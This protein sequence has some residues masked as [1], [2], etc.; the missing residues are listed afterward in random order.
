MRRL[1]GAGNGIRMGCMQ[2][3]ACCAQA[4]GA[5]SERELAGWLAA[6]PTAWHHSPPLWLGAVRHRQLA[7]IQPELP[8]HSPVSA[9]RMGGQM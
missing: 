1:H 2:V 7:R 9:D 3:L 4:P 5:S 6:A 8:L